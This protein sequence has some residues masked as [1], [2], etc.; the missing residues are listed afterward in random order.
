MQHSIKTVSEHAR[1]IVARAVSIRTA[2]HVFVVANTNYQLTNNS[3][4]Q[5]I[6]SEVHMVKK[7]LPFME[8]EGSLLYLQ[9][10]ATSTCPELE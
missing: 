5:S 4:E 8:P 1:R 6:S 3:M 2:C 10:P 7:L 9:E